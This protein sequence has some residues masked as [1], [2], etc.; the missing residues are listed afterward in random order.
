MENK[1]K[2]KVHHA[3]WEKVQ[4]FQFI[5]Q[6][7]KKNQ[8]A[9]KSFCILRYLCR[10]IVVMYLFIYITYIVNRYLYLYKIVRTS[11]PLC[12]GNGKFPPQSIFKSNTSRLKVS[13]LER[14]F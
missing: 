12:L 4:S 3:K 14:H 13:T 8:V 6:V 10:F 5:V 9:K 2:F 11:E 7:E 1:L